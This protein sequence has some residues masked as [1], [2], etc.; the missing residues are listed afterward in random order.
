[1][2]LQLPLASIRVGQPNSGTAWP[3]L[4]EHQKSLDYT[5]LSIMIN[6]F[7]KCSQ[8]ATKCIDKSTVQKLLG[9]A[10]SDHEKQ[11]ICYA[12]FKASGITPTQAR[13]QFGF[14]NMTEK[15]QQVE[16][17][18]N[19]VRAIRE[20]IDDLAKT[21]DEALLATFGIAPDNTA[22]SSNS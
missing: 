13:K 10:Q 7:L 5:K 21:Q 8:A 22:M 6:S 1:M 14:E 18:I 20:A 16:A 2:L 11:F 12:V 19:S 9:I 3:L 15:A 4:V 17:C